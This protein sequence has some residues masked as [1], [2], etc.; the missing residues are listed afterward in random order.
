MFLRNLLFV[1]LISG[2]SSIRAEGV[3]S[4][5]DYQKQG[6]TILLEVSASWC[7]FCKEQTPMVKEVLTMEQFK[8]VVF[9]EI[10]FNKDWELRE[11]FQVR[12]VPSLILFKGQAEQV[13]MVGSRNR[14]EVVSALSANL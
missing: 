12:T 14:D 13:R 6:K 8:D 10:D 5:L 9:V 3:P 1:L 11:K 2:L 4:L 7:Q